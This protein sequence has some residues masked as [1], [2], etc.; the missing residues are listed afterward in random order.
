MEIIFSI[1]MLPFI[2]LFCQTGVQLLFSLQPENIMLTS[3]W[4]IR[5]N[6]Y[7][8]QK[9]PQD[10]VCICVC[11]HTQNPYNFFFPGLPIDK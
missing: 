1:K 4:K 11:V 3:T 5:M 10:S 8:L 7:Q 2:S 6:L 9:G